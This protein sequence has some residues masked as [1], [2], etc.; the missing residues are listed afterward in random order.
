MRRGRTS[1]PRSLSLVDRNINGGN[2]N[3]L[4]GRQVDEANLL[5]GARKYTEHCSVCH[6]GPHAPPTGIAKGMF[7]PPPQLFEHMA[8]D[9]P[10]GI[11]FWKVTSGI[12]MTGM[13]AFKK[14]L[15]DTERWQV[16]MLLAHAARLP[17][18]VLAS[19]TGSTDSRPLR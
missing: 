5:V 16:T 7:P 11:T 1:S 19:L 4:F 2:S 12:R 14:T 15:S 13:P 18:R 3:G 17:A 6:G 10:E 8:T 9:D